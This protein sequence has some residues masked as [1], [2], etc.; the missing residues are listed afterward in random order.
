MT[1]KRSAPIIVSLLPSPFSLLPSMRLTSLEGKLA[2]LLSVAAIGGML[3]TALLSRWLWSPW[4]AALLSVAA[5]VLICAA[6][7]VA[8]SITAPLAS[9]LRALAG[10]VVSFRDG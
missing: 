4:I 6:L 2:A 3:A 7:L 1:R 10:S 5:I 8:R 9:L